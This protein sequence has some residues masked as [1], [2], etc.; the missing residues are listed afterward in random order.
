VKMKFFFLGTERLSHERDSETFRW[1][2]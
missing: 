2:L 1:S